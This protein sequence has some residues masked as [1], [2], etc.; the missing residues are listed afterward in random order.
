[1]SGYRFYD[2][3]VSSIR[4]SRNPLPNSLAIVLTLGVMV[5][6]DRPYWIG[7]HS[8]LQWK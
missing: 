2:C 3:M 1:M 7:F 8:S 4:D 5:G 6:G